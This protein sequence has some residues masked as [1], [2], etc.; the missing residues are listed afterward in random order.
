[1]LFEHGDI[2]FDLDLN[3]LAGLLALFFHLLLLLEVKVLL[4]LDFFLAL[5]GI[6]FFLLLML[7]VP[8]LSA[9]NFGSFLF[10]LLYLLLNLAFFE[11]KQ[12][13][14]VLQGHH[15]LLSLFA[16]L[17]R[18]EHLSVDGGGCIDNFCFLGGLRSAFNGLL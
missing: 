18:L 4:T 10:R 15:I 6:L 14:A 5:L 7:F 11:L 2:L 16:H 13:D 9:L 8:V 12:F 17:V 1:L 3:F